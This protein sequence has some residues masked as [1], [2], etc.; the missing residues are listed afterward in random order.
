[1]VVFEKGGL[2][3]LYV[4]CLDMSLDGGCCGMFFRRVYFFILSF[5]VNYCL[6]FASLFFTQFYISIYFLFFTFSNLI[7]FLN[8][9]IFF[10]FLIF[11]RLSLICFH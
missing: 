10:I 1:M 2:V 11:L 5:F 3:C 6:F 8:T 9:F 4:F 7:S